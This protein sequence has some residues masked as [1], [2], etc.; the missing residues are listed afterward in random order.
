M[1]SPNPNQQMIDD[2]NAI[3]SKINSLQDSV[4]LTDARTRIGDLQTEVSGLNQRLAI[5]R[6]RGYV[7]EKDLEGTAA[8]LSQQW[9]NLNTNL[10]TQLNSQAASLETALQPI[11]AQ[12]NQ[13]SGQVNNPAI[14]PQI[15][16]LLAAVNTLENNSEAASRSIEAMFSQYDSDVTTLTRHLTDIEWMLT[17]VAEASFKLLPTESGIAAVKAVWCKT[18]KEQKNDPEGILYLTDQRLLFEQKED[19]ATKKVLF[20]TTEKQKVQQLM[21]ETPI[22]Q[23]DKI[24][25]SKQ[26]LLKNEDHIEIQFIPGSSVDRAHFHI[27]KENASWQAMINRAKTK[28][29]D[30]GR[31]IAVD[32]S[33]VD[34]VKS[35]PSQC[36]SCG[37]NLTQP[38]LRGQ[39]SITCEY[40]GF[41]IRL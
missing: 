34:K 35:A 11:Q 19:V 29:F 33:A 27:W 25:T 38:V 9:N 36:P 30:S 26:G 28:D 18:G 10:T 41:I 3:Q 4:R 32:Q 31:T 37:G 40:C 39:D 14:R 5:I 6:S 23:A 1:A 15:A 21:L 2:I 8:G 22:V 13:L 7:F 16:G 17:Q 20:V 12:F 24:A